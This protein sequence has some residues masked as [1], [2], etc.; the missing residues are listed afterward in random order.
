MITTKGHAASVKVRNGNLRVS[1]SEEN[2]LINS[3]HVSVAV[4]SP[5]E[6]FYNDDMSIATDDYFKTLRK[7]KLDNQLKKLREEKHHKY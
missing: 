5:I 4:E 3:S 1:V 2:N 6:E 7:E